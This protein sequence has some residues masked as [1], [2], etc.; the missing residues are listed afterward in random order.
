MLEGVGDVFTLGHLFIPM[1]CRILSMLK[2]V[3]LVPDVHVVHFL[4][5]CE[6]RLRAVGCTVLYPP[7]SYMRVDEFLL[8]FAIE[9]DAYIVTLDEDFLLLA[10]ER[11]ILLPAGNKFRK[12]KRRT[13]EE[14]W[15]ILCRKIHEIRSGEK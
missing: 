8:K 15:T 13:Y 5:W 1:L 7:K 3:K 12:V 11:T 4:R 9:N 10:P 6:R 2:I 14:W